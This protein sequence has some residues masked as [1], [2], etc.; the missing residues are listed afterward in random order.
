MRFDILNKCDRQTDGQTVGT[1]ASNSQINKKTC[2]SVYDEHYK[3]RKF[4]RESFNNCD[5]AMH[6]VVTKAS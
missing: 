1:G 3:R 2:R 6:C 5:I 4:G